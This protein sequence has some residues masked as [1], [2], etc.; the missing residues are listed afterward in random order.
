MPNPDPE[1]T[2]GIYD[3]DQPEN[4]LVELTHFRGVTARK[5]LRE[6]GTCRFTVNNDDVQVNFIP[7]GRCVAKFRL[8]G[9]VVES[10]LIE[11]SVRV[12]R[13][14]EE[15]GGEATEFHGVSTLG[16]LREAVVYPEKGSDAEPYSDERLFDFTSAALDDSDW[17][18]AKLIKLQGASGTPYD[19][20]PVN[21]PDALAWWVWGDPHTSPQPVGDCYFRRFIN[22]A[23]ETPVR[24]FITADD[25]F[26]LYVDGVPL[27]Q[28][29]QA[30]L[31]RETRSVDTFLS[32]DQHLI[33]V[34]AT[35]VDRP[36]N[37][38]TNIGAVI[39][40]V[41]ALSEGGATL[42]TL[43]DDT[44]ADWRSLAYPLVPAGFTVGRLLRT[45]V[46]EA[47]ARL[48]LPGVTVSF[49]NTHDSA[50]TAWPSVH[51]FAFP[52]GRSLFE[53]VTEL[54]EGGYCDVAM[55]PVN[56]TLHAWVS[57]GTATGVAL[58]AGD[59]DSEAAQ[60]LTEA[61][62]NLLELIHE[63]RA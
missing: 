25:A 10:F 30:Y 28:E 16:L 9:T 62:G 40:A 42:G 19:T 8:D 46:D 12:S 60:T 59:D 1:L 45:L 21:W 6:L 55:D 61:T 52:V 38:S 32:I 14:A 56:H 51:E 26:E 58:V 33:A 54:V 47:Q 35:N 53:V 41:Y 13:S 24:I 2:I 23:T 36:S 31:W 50:G 7:L 5:A 43:I 37:P 29:A 4:L 15:E 48:C 44:D 20:A 3:R 17:E 49:S 57:R 18:N 27:A 34:K 63:R 11:R 39:V 22:V